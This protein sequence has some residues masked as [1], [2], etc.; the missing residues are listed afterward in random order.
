MTIL[1]VE[2]SASYLNELSETL[3]SA[4][5]EVAPVKGVMLVADAL[6]LIRV[7]ELASTIELALVDLELRGAANQGPDDLE[8]LD[9]ILRALRQHAPWIPAV[10]VSRYLS[11]DPLVLSRVSPYGFD[12]LLPKRFFSESRTYK[13]SWQEVRRLAALNRVAALTGRSTQELLDLVQ[14]PPL[15]EYGLGVEGEIGKYGHENFR[16]ALVLSDLRGTRLVIDNVSPGFSGL[17]TAKVTF[18]R[19]RR[20]VSWFLKFGSALAK[21]EQEAVSHRKMSLDGLT[22]SLSVPLL[23]WHPVVLEGRGCHSVRVRRDGKELRGGGPFHGSCLRVDS[24]CSSLNRVIQ[25]GR[26]WFSY[27]AAGASRPVQFCRESRVP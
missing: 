21:L 27:S 15:I 4:F 18:Q 23:W 12:V 2:D 8:G 5:Q 24:D 14:S 9:T 13:S 3:T 22:R 20:R 19:G 1:I 6:A 11:G 16:T 17:S 10:A 25:G 7:P 26:G